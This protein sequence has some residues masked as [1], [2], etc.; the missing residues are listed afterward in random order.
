MCRNIGGVSPYIRWHSPGDHNTPSLSEE[1]L[2]PYNRLDPHWWR[3]RQARSSLVEAS[4]CS[5]LIGR[6]SCELGHPTVGSVIIGPCVCLLGPHWSRCLRARSP[7]GRLIPHW[8]RFLRARSSLVEVSA[9]SVLIGRGAYM[10]DPHWSRFL[11]ARS[12]LVVIPAC[13][14]LIGRVAHMRKS[15]R[16]AKRPSFC[17]LDKAL[18][19]YFCKI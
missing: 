9:Y 17:H 16:G 15:I 10:L 6:D 2:L 12:P 4:A 14:V 13:S 11:L 5:V 1:E 19:L 18:L 3:F 7:Y 8:S